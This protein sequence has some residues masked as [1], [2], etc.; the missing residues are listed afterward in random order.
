MLFIEDVAT[1]IGVLE[2]RI[3]TLEAENAK[4]RGDAG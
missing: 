3:A 4:L 2:E 1:A